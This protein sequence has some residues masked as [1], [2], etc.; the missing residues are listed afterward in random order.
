MRVVCLGARGSSPSPGDEFRETGGH[1][2][3]VAIAPDGGPCE[4]VLDAGTGIRGLATLLDGAPF[5]GT[6]VLTHLHWDHIIG[7]PFS[8]PLM[9][10]G[11]RVRLLVPADGDPASLLERMISPP[12]VPVTL[13]HLPGAWSIEP[14]SEGVI[15]LGPFEVTALEIPHGGG[16]TFGLR[17]DDGAAG[18]AYLPDH[19]PRIAGPGPGGLGVPSGGAIA[20][21]Q[22]VDLLVHDAHWAAAEIDGRPTAGHA[23]AEFALALARAAHAHRLWLFH[24]HPDRTDGAVRAL[25]AALDPTGVET[26]IAR[27][28]LEITLP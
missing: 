9:D 10:P 17:V 24:H 18:L 21:A 19:D 23:S 28:G 6:I 7:L 8:R 22:D 3:C 14:L 13:D 25:A 20:L 26:T 1:T 11:A 5:R 12:F 16:T 27:S 4:L 15:D 2:C